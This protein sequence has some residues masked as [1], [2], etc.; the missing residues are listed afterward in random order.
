MFRPSKNAHNNTNSS[1]TAQTIHLWGRKQHSRSPRSV[2][3]TDDIDTPAPVSPKPEILAQPYQFLLEIPSTPTKEVKSAMSVSS[4][5]LLDWGRKQ[6]RQIL[7]LDDS[8]S[9]PMAPG[10]RLKE[11]HVQQYSRSDLQVG[12][13][14]GEGGFACVFDVKVKS[15]SSTKKKSKLA[16]KQLRPDLLNDED[17]FGKAARSLV[18]E[19]AIMQTLKGHVNILELRG[20]SSDARAPLCS[21]EGF[22]ALFLVTDAL[23]ETM[24][25]RLIRWT[26]HLVQQPAQQEQRWK[27][28][29]NYALQIAQALA[30]C[31]ENRIIYRD[32]KCSNIGFSDKHTIKLFDFGLSRALPE[33]ECISDNDTESSSVDSRYGDEDIFRMTICGTQRYM[34]PEVYNKGWYNLKS[35]VYSWSMTTVELLTHKKPYSFMSLPVH[36]ILV[37]EEGRRPAIEEYPPGFQQILQKA[38]AQNVANR[39]S[40]V[41]VCDALKAHIESEGTTQLLALSAPTNDDIDDS[42]RALSL[43]PSKHQPGTTTFAGFQQERPPLNTARAI[44]VPSAA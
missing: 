37:L 11:Q 12:R 34:A 31:H 42:C 7:S 16:L 25:S 39:W 27:Y 18:Q 8:C 33:E 30:F 2:T 17:L 3:E 43:P 20:I 29:L 21:R 40:M 26:K 10:N 4:L 22:D 5:R 41:E 6:H 9:V 24:E 44:F 19:A 32:C 15:S 28:K 36:K 14:L 38:W 13:L 23:K 1:L 35:D